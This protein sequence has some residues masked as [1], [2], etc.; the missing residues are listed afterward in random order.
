MERRFACGLLVFATAA[1]AGGCSS[2]PALTDRD[3]LVVADVANT[4]GDAVFD[5]GLKAAVQVAL[6]Q[7]PSLV[8][9][10]D[11][12][13]QRFLRQ[14]QQPV[15][16][17]V[18]GDTAREL[19]KRAGARATIEPAIATSGSGYAITLTAHDCQTGSSLASAKTSASGKTDVV[20]KLGVAVKELRTALGEAAATRDKYDADLVKA[21]S[22]NVEALRAYGQGLRM[23]AVRGDEPAAPL[24]AQAAKLDPA[25][26]IAYAKLAV[27]LA[28]I[29]EVAGARDQ[30]EKAYG[31]RDQMTE[32]ERLYITWN[33]GARVKADPA[34]IKAGLEALT[35]T[36]PRDFAARNNFGV[37][38]NNAG[39]LEDALKQYQAA[40]EIA[41]DEPSPLANSAYVLLMLGRYDEASTMVDRTLAVRP[42]ANLAVTRWISARVADLPRAAEFETV[43]QQL[44]GADQMAIAKASLAAW[45]GQFQPFQRMEDDLI[46]KARATG[47]G[48]L[49]DGV[50]IGRAITLAAYR[51]GRDVDALKAS[52]A[53]EKNIAFLVQQTS[54]LAML[55]EID[56][57]RANLKRLEADKQSAGL[58][59]PLTVARSYVQARD[60]HPAEAIAALQAVLTDIPRA[61]DL[62]F[63]IADIKEH[64]GDDAGAIAGYRVVINSLAY[65]GPN[66][67]IPLSRLRLAKLLVKQGDQAGAKE[68]LDVLLKQWKDADGEFAALTEAKALRAKIG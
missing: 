16:Q 25:F 4:T 52:A 46:A 19:C 2:A 24:F 57:A 51:G 11:Q 40:S 42:D 56:A 17:A 39:A 9:V 5:D 21:T 13:L 61:R 48:D 34:L 49:A 27:V 7:S 44:A 47:Q 58:G 45:S 22:A 59:P 54:G 26:G 10:S 35:T 28:N 29:G 62:N 60:G 6:Q 68:Q 36:Y 66:P 20:E 14:M 37:Y 64:S 38:Y 8:L 63:Y 55:G 1:F 15:D 53:R 41:P 31:L 50:A 32:Y 33:Y 65:L 12:R 3:T 18:T 67:L 30:T 23:R 43:A